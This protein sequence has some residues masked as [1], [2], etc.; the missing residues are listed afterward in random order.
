MNY[1]NQF[2]AIFSRFMRNQASKFDALTVLGLMKRLNG[3]DF[4]NEACRSLEILNHWFELFLQ[5]SKKYE[6]S[7]IDILI[8]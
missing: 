3:S 8:T 7:M 2:F 5:I 4:A 6:K 1:H